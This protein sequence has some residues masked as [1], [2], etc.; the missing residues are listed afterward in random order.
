MADSGRLVA[1][2]PPDLLPPDPTR[3]FTNSSI[4]GL[5]RIVGGGGYISVSFKKCVN[6][7]GDTD[8]K[9]WRLAC[10]VLSSRCFL[11]AAS[12]DLFASISAR[13]RSARDVA[14]DIV[15]SSDKSKDTR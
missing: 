3:L 15:Y 10:L 7:S 1:L 13:R 2:L 4:S 8:A 14:E 9:S 5:S 11:R 6:G 12:F